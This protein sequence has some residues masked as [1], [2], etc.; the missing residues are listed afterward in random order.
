MAKC[1]KEPNWFLK[2]SEQKKK[3]IFWCNIQG[4]SGHTIFTLCPDLTYPVHITNT[5]LLIWNEYWWYSLVCHDRPC[6]NIVGILYKN[7]ISTKNK[8]P[9]LLTIKNSK[10]NKTTLARIKVN[11]GLTRPVVVLNQFHMYS[12]HTGTKSY[13]LY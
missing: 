11:F 3:T 4:Q 13:T 6:T 12:V 5:E 7:G 1:Y 10:T 9:F 2:S 8:I